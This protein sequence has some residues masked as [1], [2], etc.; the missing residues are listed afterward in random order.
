MRVEHKKSVLAFV[1]IVLALVMSAIG[2]TATS[3]F[4]RLT[5]AEAATVENPT[6]IALSVNTDRAGEY[7]PY[8]LKANALDGVSNVTKT[9]YNTYLL[10]DGCEF[11]VPSDDFSYFAFVKN[12][13]NT[14]TE[15]LKLLTNLTLT[16]ADGNSE[17]ISCATD[18][19][20]LE[21]TDTGI[22]ATYKGLSCTLSLNNIQESNAAGITAKYD[23]ILN[24]T[25][26]MAV[27]GKDPEFKAYSVM[28]N[29][30]V[31][32]TPLG[33]NEFNIP[34]RQ[35]FS[36]PDDFSIDDVVFDGVNYFYFKEININLRSGVSASGSFFVKVRYAGITDIVLDLNNY[37]SVPTQAQT[38]LE[39]FVPTDIDA[40]LTIGENAV[41]PIIIN[42]DYD[43]APL[44]NGFYRNGLGKYKIYYYEKGST[45]PSISGKTD[46]ELLQDETHT[47]GNE[48]PTYMTSIVGTIRI[49][50]VVEANGK[51]QTNSVVACKD[52]DVSDI[53]ILPAAI[54]APTL[55]GVTAL[56][57]KKFEQSYVKSNGSDIGENPY[58]GYGAEIPVSLPVGYTD[59][60][61]FLLGREVK[62][63]VLRGAETVGEYGYEYNGGNI[64]NVK[65]E[66]GVSFAETADGS[67]Y[68]VAENAGNYTVRFE[69]VGPDYK[70]DT[71]VGASSDTLLSYSVT[72]N[73]MKGSAT[74]GIAKGVDE[75]G[76]E[77]TV[78]TFNYGSLLKTNGDIGYGIKYQ[79]IDAELAWT[80]VDYDGTSS[81]WTS[82]IG[83]TAGDATETEFEYSFLYYGKST[84]GLYDVPASA[85]TSSVPTTPGTY[86]AIIKVEAFGNYAE[87][88]SE[89]VEFIIKRQA[90]AFSWKYNLSG[91]PNYKS[92]PIYNAGK[93]DTSDYIYIVNESSGEVLT[94]T[95]WNFYT[96]DTFATVL[97]DYQPIVAGKHTLYLKLSE[98]KSDL[99]EWSPET[100]S[101]IDDGIFEAGDSGAGKATL[102]FEIEK[103]VGNN[104]GVSISGW[105]Y[106]DNANEP[107]DSAPTYYKEIKHIFVEKDV[108]D[109]AKT[110]A[111]ALSGDDRGFVAKY[112][113]TNSLAFTTDAPVNAGDYFV[114]AYITSEYGE[115]S[116][117]FTSYNYCEAAK[118]FT[119]DKKG[120]V[121]PTLGM[122]DF[123][124]D[125]NAQTVELLNYDGTNMTVSISASLP[126]NTSVSADSVLGK[127]T[128]TN[129]DSYTITVKIA[130]E[131]FKNHKWDDPSVSGDTFSFTW[132]IKPYTLKSIGRTLEKE[133][134]YSSSK[135][136]VV[137][138]DDAN[139]SD[140]FFD[141]SLINAS[142]SGNPYMNGVLDT[143]K[144]FISTSLLSQDASK[145]WTFGATYAGKYVV[146]LSLNDTNYIWDTNA[147][148]YELTFDITPV[149]LG[150][151][152][153]DWGT[154]FSYIYD[155]LEHKPAPVFKELKGSDALTAS[156][157]VKNGEEAVARVTEV[158]NYVMA[159][160]GMSGANL[161]GILDG[162]DYNIAY[163]YVMPETAENVTY[164][165]FA[166]T[167]ALL[168]AP[169]FT[170]D[171]VEYNG[172]AFDIIDYIEDYAK[173][174][175]IGDVAQIKFT[176][177]KNGTEAVGG[178][179]PQDTLSLT[180]V[181]WQS[182][183]SDKATIG[184]Y[185]V[186]VTLRDP[187]NYKWK[188]KSDDSVGT[189]NAPVSLT[190]KITPALVDFVLSQD[191]S[192]EK[193]YVVGYDGVEHDFID[194]IQ[195][196]V[197]IENHISVS[198]GK[199]TD[200][201]RAAFGDAVNSYEV[202]VGLDDKTKYNYVWAD[203]SSDPSQGY[204]I[205]DK[206]YFMR[207]DPAA[208]EVDWADLE[209]TY[210]GSYL[211]PTASVSNHFEVEDN[212]SLVLS[213]EYLEGKD[214]TGTSGG[215]ANV[216]D[217]GY[218]TAYVVG[219]T[220]EG[221]ENYKIDFSSA[222]AVK[223]KANFTI[224]RAAVVKPTIE[225]ALGAGNSLGE[226]DKSEH[227][228]V[229]KNYDSARM[230]YAANAHD[231]RGKDVGSITVPHSADDSNKK[232]T[233]SVKRAGD[234]FVT[235]TLS[236]GKN[237]CF[238]DGSTA[239]DAENDNTVTLDF[240]LERKAVNAPTLSRSTTREAG[241]IFVPVLYS[242]YGETV[243]DKKYSEAKDA[244]SSVDFDLGGDWVV[245]ANIVYGNVTSDAVGIYDI[246]L[247][248][249]LLTDAESIYDYAFV[250]E[251][252]DENTMSTLG[253][254][255][256]LLDFE[257]VLK[258]QFRITGSVFELEFTIQSADGTAVAEWTYGDDVTGFRFHTDSVIPSDYVPAQ[259]E[260][261][262]YVYNEDDKSYAAYTGE[263][264]STGSD[265]I[266][267]KA[268]FFAA[269]PKSAGR[270]RA[271]VIYRTGDSTGNGVY[272]Y[273]QRYIVEFAIEKKEVAF[274]WQSSEVNGVTYDAVEN[275]FAAIYDGNSHMGFAA[276]T[277]SQYGDTLGLQIGLAGDAMDNPVDV[278]LDADKNATYYDI[279]IKSI[280]GEAAANYV[281]PTSGLQS[282][283]TIDKRSVTLNA[284]DA[285]HIFG[286]K[287]T[288]DGANLNIDGA[289][290]V[291]ITDGDF[292]AS[293]NISLD[294]FAVTAKKSDGTYVLYN[295]S[296]GNYKT[297]ITP[298]AELTN[299]D[300]TYVDGVFD[301]EQKVI[302][303]QWNSDKFVYDGTDQFANY[304]GKFVWYEDVDANKVALESVDISG[305]DTIF[306][307]AGRYDFAVTAVADANYRLA[308]SGE[309]EYDSLTRSIE[310]QKR[311][312]NIA[313]KDVTTVY[314]D[315]VG[316]YPLGWVYVEGT[317]KFVEDGGIEIESG[318]SA[319]SVLSFG[320]ASTAVGTS[321]VGSYVTYLVYNG[322]N[323]TGQIT[324]DDFTVN[325]EKGAHT[326][327]KYELK[328]TDIV[329]NE[330]S[331]VYNAND[332][333]TQTLGLATYADRG[334]GSTH[335]LL[336]AAVSESGAEVEFKNAGDYT[337]AVSSLQSDSTANLKLPDGYD[338]AWKSA[339]K[340]TIAKREVEIS[341]E[342]SESVYG[343][344]IGS[345]K[346]VWNYVST[347]KF[348]D[349]DENAG[350]DGFTS[351]INIRVAGGEGV[352]DERTDVGFCDLELFHGNDK[353]IATGGKAEFANYSVVFT[354]G[355]IT[356]RPRELKID[357]KNLE[358]IYGSDEVFDTP[359]VSRLAEIS[360]SQIVGG[361]LASFDTIVDVL[362]ATTPANPDGRVRAEAKNGYAV[363]LSLNTDAK[364]D[365]YIVKFKPVSAAGDT[366]AEVILNSDVLNESAQ[367][368]SEVAAYYNIKTA[369]FE[370]IQVVSY[371]ESGIAYDGAVHAAISSKSVSYYGT[372][373]SEARKTATEN[374]SDN[375]LGWA[376]ALS[377]E[378]VAPD[379][380]AFA[381]EIPEVLNA[382]TYYLY[383][384]ISA[385]NHE[386]EIGYV[387]VT[388]TK[389]E[390]VLSVSA[391][392]YYGENTPD[393]QYFNYDFD[394]LGENESITFASASGG[395]VSFKAVRAIGGKE[396]PLEGWIDGTL[397]ISTDYIAGDSVGT[398]RVKVENLGFAA[399]NYVF[400]IAPEEQNIV[401]VEKL[402]VIITVGD[403]ED[404]YWF[405]GAGS[406]RDLN[407]RAE[408]GFTLTTGVKDIAGNSITDVYAG[409]K[410]VGTHEYEKL[411]FIKSGAFVYDANGNRTDMNGVGTYT[412]TYER[413]E[414]GGVNGNYDLSFTLGSHKV[415]PADIELTLKGYNADY[416]ENE[417]DLIV[418]TA[419]DGVLASPADKERPSGASILDFKYAL[420]KVSEGD[421]KIEDYAPS[422]ENGYD[423]DSV[424]KLIDAGTYYVYYMI[425]GEN[426][427]T[428]TGSLTAEIA[429]VY[430]GW[431][432]DKEYA[433][434]KSYWSYGSYDLSANEETKPE[435]NF[436]RV[437]SGGETLPEISL[438][439][440][441]DFATLVGEYS[442]SGEHWSWLT[443]TI[444]G[445]TYNNG[446]LLGAGVYKVVVSVDGNDNFYDLESEYEITVN[447]AELSLAPKAATITYGDALDFDSLKFEIGSFKNGEDFSSEI[448]NEVLR[449]EAGYG[450]D[451]SFTHYA[452][453]FENG[454]VSNTYYIR[455]V[456]GVQ[457]I[458]E[459]M[460][461]LKNYAPVLETAT[462]TVNKKPLLIHI[463]NAEN[464]YNFN[465]SSGEK[466]DPAAIDTDLT[467]AENKDAAGYYYDGE[468]RP[469]G[470]EIPVHIVTD[471]FIYDESGN[472]A[473]STKDVGKYPIYAEENKYAANYDIS[474]EGSYSGG[475]KGTFEIKQAELNIN[476]SVWH[477][478]DG[479]ETEA[480][481]AASGREYVGTYS[482]YAWEFKAEC[483][484][485]DFDDVTFRTVYRSALSGIDYTGVAP[486]N[487][488]TYYLRF[489][490]N[491]NNN[492][493]FAGS[494][495]DYVMKV[496]PLS[497]AVDMRLYEDASGTE[498][499]TGSVEY[500]QS[501]YAVKLSSVPEAVPNPDREDFEKFINISYRK[502]NESVSSPLNA[503]SYL[504]TAT[505]TELAYGNY[506][507]DETSRN[508]QFTITKKKIN[509]VT[510]IGDT[511]AVY[512]GNDI[513]FSLAGCS[514]LTDPN[515]E[516]GYVMTYEIEYADNLGSAPSKF[517][518]GH[519]AAGTFGFGA[520]NAGSYAVKVKLEF[521][522]DYEW[523]GFAGDTVT[524]NYTITQKSLYVKASN[525]KIEYGDLFDGSAGSTHSLLYK[526]LV[527]G[528][529]GQQGTQGNEIPSAGIIGVGKEIDISSVTYA[530]VDSSANAH[531]A[532]SAAGEIFT[533]IPNSDE[534][535]SN[536]YNIVVNHSSFGSGTLSVVG[537][538]ITV[539]IKD[540][541][542]TYTGSKHDEWL[543]SELEASL[544]SGGNTGKYI[545]LK[546]GDLTGNE[547]N[548]T[549]ADLGITLKIGGGNE[550]DC[551]LKGFAI[552]ADYTN[553]NY[554]I[555]FTGSW[556]TGTDGT[557]TIEKKTLEVFVG[558]SGD[559]G[560]AHSVIYGDA[561]IY[562]ATYS[563]F[564]PQGNVGETGNLSA[565]SWLFLSGSISYKT[566]LT[567]GSGA[568]EYT[569]GESHVGDE[570]KV[571]IDDI[572][573]QNYKFDIN[574]GTIAILPRTIGASLTAKTVTF[575]ADNAHIP[576]VQNAP[577]A[578]TNTV[579]GFAS[580]IFTYSYDGVLKD[581][582]AVS[583][584]ADVSRAGD[585][586]V[587][588]NLI[589]NENGEYDYLFA[590]SVASYTFAD[591]YEIAKQ[592]VRLE[593]TTQT[594]EF[595]EGR[596]DE[597]TIP[598]YDGVIL[599]RSGIMLGGAVDMEI[600]GGIRIGEGGKGLVLPVI[601]SGNYSIVLSL[602]PDYANDYIL[603]NRDSPQS[604]TVT[605]SFNT[606]VSEINLT[607]SMSGWTYGD[608]AVE[609]K[610]KATEAGGKDFALD[611]NATIAISYALLSE[612]TIA[613]LDSKNLWNM[614]LT[615]NDINSLDGTR[616][617][618]VSPVNAGAYMV[619]ATGS[620]DYT[621]ESSDTG[622]TE[623]KRIPV[624]A[625]F[626]FRIAKDKID[627]P[628]FDEEGADKVY[629]GS[630]LSATVSGYREGIMSMT[631]AEAFELKAGTITL[632]T[633]SA[634]A[635]E[636][637]VSLINDTNYEWNEFTPSEHTKLENGN[638]IITWTVTAGTNT[639][640]GLTVQTGIYYG[641]TYDS[642]GVSALFGGVITYMYASR[643]TD[644][645]DPSMVPEGLDWKVGFPKGVGK[646]WIGATSQG[647]EDDYASE[648]A[649]A[650]CEI[651]KA[652]LAVRPK[653]TALTYGEAFTIEG[654]YELVGAMYD[655][656]PV[657]GGLPSATVSNEN[658]NYFVGADVG[659]YAIRISGLS[660][661]AVSGELA[662]N[663]S[664]TF[665]G[666]ETATL[667]VNKKSITV[668]INSQEATYD[669]TSDHALDE[670]MGE[671]NGWYVLNN[672]L[673]TNETTQALDTLGIALSLPDNCMNVGNYPISY[674]FT[675]VGKNDNYDIT[676]TP[677]G[678]FV[679][680]SLT[681]TVT[682]ATAGGTLVYNR[683]N[684]PTGNL[685]LTLKY[686]YDGSEQTLIVDS[687]TAS[688]T[689][690][691]ENETFVLRY[692]GVS[693]NGATYSNSPSLPLFAGSGYTVGLVSGTN[694]GNITL[695]GASA[696][697]AVEKYTLDGALIQNAASLKN[698]LKVAYTGNEYS[699][700]GDVANRVVTLGSALYP[701]PSGV[702]KLFTVT[703]SDKQVS[704]GTYGFTLT[705]E[706]AVFHNY[707]WASVEVAS[708]EFTFEIE[709]AANVVR[710]TG[711]NP[712]ELSWVYDG[713]LHEGGLGVT[714][715]FGQ[716]TKIY[717]VSSTENGTYEEFDSVRHTRKGTYYVKV[718]IPETNDYTE[719]T[720]SEYKVCDISARR[721]NLVF[722]GD[723]EYIGGVYGDTSMSARDY[724]FTDAVT[725]LADFDDLKAGISVSIVYVGSS[726]GGVASDGLMPT[727][728]GRY[729]VRISLSGE[730]AHN[731][732]LA[733]AT[734]GYVE[735]NYIVARQAVYG[736]RIV[737]ESFD[738]DGFAHTAE[739]SVKKNE[740]Y[741]VKYELDGEAI[742]NINAS[743]YSF[744]LKLIDSDNFY[745]FTHT[746]DQTAETI[747]KFRSFSYHIKTVDV[748]NAELDKLSFFKNGVKVEVSESELNSETML[749]TYKDVISDVTATVVVTVRTESGREFE[750]TNRTYGTF[751][752]FIE[753]Q[754]YSENY[755]QWGR[756]LPEDAG[757]HKIRVNI[758]RT[759]NINAPTSTSE[760]DFGVEKFALE[761]PT[762][763]DTG[764]GWIYTGNR[765]TAYMDGSFDNDVMRVSFSD[766]STEGGRFTVGAVKAGSHEITVDIRSSHTRNYMWKDGSSSL[767]IVWKIEK[768]RNGLKHFDDISKIYG[769][770]YASEAIAD[771]GQ[772]QFAY[773]D[774][775]GKLLAGAPRASGDYFIEAY[776]DG[777]DDYYGVAAS[778]VKLH[779]SK[780]EIV[781]LPTSGSVVYGNEY[782]HDDRGFLV[783]DGSF[784]YG[785]GY[786]VISG[787]PVYYT[788]YR[789]GNAVGSTQTIAISGVGILEAENYTFKAGENLASLTVTKRPIT[790]LIGDQSASYNG[791]ILLDET[792]WTIHE[793]TPKFG[794]DIIA[795][796]LSIEGG[797]PTSVGRYRIIG[798]AV[799]GGNNS[800]E[801]YDIT[802]R[803]GTYVVNALIIT[804]T[805]ID[806]PSGLV[807]GE[808]AGAKATFTVEGVDGALESGAFVGR[809]EI[810]VVYYDDTT[811]ITYGSMPA[812]AGTYRAMIE[813]APASDGNNNQNYRLGGTLSKVF[814]IARRAI[815]ETSIENSA[816]AAGLLDSVYSGFLRA[817]S[818][819]A[820]AMIEGFAPIDGMYT[821]SCAGGINVG[822]YSLLLT[823]TSD[824][825]RNY[826]WLHSEGSV[827]SL[828]YTIT[829]NMDNAVTA[830]FENAD[831]AT[832][833]YDGN[834][835]E[836]RLESRLV[837]N[838]LLGGDNVFFEY[839][840]VSGDT[841]GEYSRAVPSAV[842]DYR[843]R[844]V[845]KDTTDYS[846]AVST[847]LR[848]EITPRRI[849]ADFAECGGMYMSA[850]VPA[851]AI[852]AYADESF[853]DDRLLK[854][855]EHSVYYYGTSYDGTFSHTLED[856]ITVVPVKA[857]A[858]KAAIV[859][860][861][862]NFVFVSQG[863]E[864]NT[865]ETDFIVARKRL[866]LPAQDGGKYEVEDTKY[867][868]TP[869]GFDETVMTI[870]GNSANKN[871]DYTAIV[872]LKDKANYEWANGTSDDFEMSWTLKKDAPVDFIATVSVLST[873]T[874]AA[875]ALLV[876]MLVRR[877]KLGY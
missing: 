6:S 126:G 299:Y 456:G 240:K 428:V 580:E 256:T 89:P 579:S 14:S 643:D 374:V 85:P 262:Y 106:E 119:V 690:L 445:E 557:F 323:F 417:H 207:V 264:V 743:H 677:S 9:D 821:V 490:A 439:G 689:I 2:F 415:V 796:T 312:V 757:V 858:Y 93:H 52:F 496:N 618:G 492:Y 210:S 291:R 169:T 190:F 818:A 625:W 833:E 226:Y 84:N 449:L 158:G 541:S 661:V 301:V 170:D 594:F 373:K 235:F 750:L 793:S 236:D 741:G 363:T 54:M 164:H 440:G 224:I 72:V 480:S 405:N 51:D 622:T 827:A 544:A 842:G 402:P 770:E 665:D 1:G 805:G 693:N 491:N 703:A 828:T 392:I 649:Y 378:T 814:T 123:T 369:S 385:D 454:S 271:A 873:M 488:G 364:G 586:I 709:K 218:Y 361:G 329:W 442:M 99:Y 75:E 12:A 315:V 768:A 401:S 261:V 201:N 685:S 359:L 761:T 176:A 671:K 593:W 404:S 702:D 590:G 111:D 653:D 712:G 317:D 328:E 149:K 749:W 752:S 846:G 506:I 524:L 29:G 333:T 483:V 786:A 81:S 855:A 804:V 563:G 871:G 441:E 124:F 616:T 134:E 79:P 181:V 241:K 191:A 279:E 687:A 355:E 734:S 195:N 368:T 358:H 136:T 249:S 753:L 42:L 58:G 819:D 154:E 676:V 514:S 197:G 336:L 59:L 760:Y 813:L 472:L 28:S 589:T 664:V 339:D 848:F 310:M 90:I 5:N 266:T 306:K 319:P 640:S 647:G 792:K 144:S 148:S 810:L 617:Y 684:A 569:I 43:R 27:F 806:V 697:F 663:Y 797:L 715:D 37:E 800:N 295:T 83:E 424:P 294:S 56:D 223:P 549:V 485:A 18:G 724:D 370:D 120:V 24:A 416:D 467:S 396:L 438:F 344:K 128:A 790:I 558:V 209:Q 92:A 399:G 553:K 465:I 231:V 582:T 634:G 638:V 324:L 429:K 872:S 121:K 581:G 783:E 78:A 122:L 776:V 61:G 163:G 520:V 474:Y 219:L 497:V 65:I 732:E 529:I 863:K 670:S 114:L 269:L 870:S 296:V 427:N 799:S 22:N 200:V 733:N 272:E 527:Q 215:L 101:G 758:E 340:Y 379:A 505:V 180:D 69:I 844:A 695:I 596:A 537:R 857:G 135:Q 393:L 376:Y 845:V 237:Y 859:L 555:A 4:A 547:G 686:V 202:T 127:L 157:S 731:F 419:S 245:S 639:V 826:K 45:V 281:L 501:P 650:A 257:T 525:E 354:N 536:N 834:S 406:G 436:K 773:Y 476:V 463:N 499:L 332:R 683:G 523:I 7:P 774:K 10:S 156:V 278:K 651:V 607:I 171:V 829:K 115:N 381:S 208:L 737:V 145:V 657:L 76:A 725:G 564:V 495:D 567:A 357:V 526:G 186:V 162:M 457:S 877:K 304:N 337:L 667:T 259:R 592:V 382:G 503:G 350:I 3:Q 602:K 143:D 74:L 470:A 789:A 473:V 475:T 322:G 410:S 450:N 243:A 71:A 675:S 360:A 746:E 679:I 46:E 745:W 234:Y 756:L 105:T 377:T 133:S 660:G 335:E 213:L 50:Y 26:T 606:F 673:V 347:V 742:E 545:I 565:L 652:V 646:Y 38:A 35:D 769:E 286:S 641:E 837:V 782:T 150:A 691:N 591:S 302:E 320:F 267:N 719:A 300:I 44:E 346:R 17:T 507:L 510:T 864:T 633:S 720:T 600:D 840:S 835:I 182:I 738:F 268:D 522:D 570:Y 471:A 574:E 48:L 49:L 462:L 77:N 609:P 403:I 762:L 852:F 601:K 728:A 838:A 425:S 177:Y 433:I 244:V 311:T 41:S 15:M 494:A 251:E 860:Q 815:D 636:L 277:N 386:T 542:R 321:S 314:G 575:A 831:S 710:W 865:L 98:E 165:A 613:S 825:V 288:S 713:T 228:V 468:N 96:D 233:V 611:E 585:Y 666:S 535:V 187:E 293:D 11:A 489:I 739:D 73:P 34:T 222:A 788:A 624:Q 658:G 513:T 411:F 275:M 578:F 447:K 353:F 754:Y 338:L 260:A 345:E 125:K 116:D 284:G 214:N 874:V 508:F 711:A 795:I 316:S 263:T 318:N 548:D 748:V 560:K 822:E 88:H 109:T 326:I 595:A 791:E 868:L 747:N 861:N 110:A 413:R 843:V 273:E 287:V 160:D 700:D 740:F 434:A 784:E 451:E 192:E 53:D 486:K 349:D 519:F 232:I 129:V 706:N 561:L 698:V 632:H 780:K 778:R 659:E 23:K 174:Y 420:I 787:A 517:G 692:S 430:N 292:V 13:A 867:T 113:I 556:S 599:D 766:V 460:E 807:F 204:N 755:A 280:T 348:C 621:Y 699:I 173:N 637:T 540:A 808:T 481:V 701:L 568:A 775:D 446:Q 459:G 830:K 351:D 482:G 217:A 443:D 809:V 282:K 153:V 36:P 82:G 707:K 255:D 431:K 605:L 816:K 722:A 853:S 141:Y 498:A 654:N 327:E 55:N 531:T 458:L 19:V 635:H 849:T 576:V 672:A 614:S 104:L 726:F 812:S 108:Y 511:S 142:V 285:S 362:T 572:T 551:S 630:L 183:A 727:L 189:D 87:A 832:F 461:V 717:L 409:D 248:L 289:N 694:S 64:Q 298:R 423:L 40:Y 152:N 571:T 477:S 8:Y 681:L 603:V 620:V 32:T 225:T 779:I 139:A 543:Q 573:L 539:E 668:I 391:N 175:I 407:V 612:E 103:Y 418:S 811:G 484:N 455:F 383:Y 751:D 330:S 566:V 395:K 185:T 426:H 500:K 824:F 343:E 704:A 66:N 820:I 94:S 764:T 802:F 227:D 631:Y 412:V 588:L 850:I 414:L 509:V 866:E 619:R 389:K 432:T 25:D 60:W 371:S 623:T 387:T 247:T 67:Q 86:Y 876:V 521:T 132:T 205:A 437:P 100:V 246:T 452:A 168:L 554:D 696:A 730:S 117:D 794:S 841:L 528:H 290:L 583:S 270:Y 161:T 408:N 767:V 801:N 341:V 334:D 138:F 466:E 199:H 655:D 265:D 642:T 196:Y 598:N 68:L 546:S 184:S 669:G 469:F 736:D 584:L 798:E 230:S 615:Q 211:S 352:D 130:A 62:M 516:N 70:W 552:S 422:D 388:V 172:S 203:G 147:R 610:L 342:D 759:V 538:K 95:D 723:D 862:E 309:S 559:E 216:T 781:V 47:G 648:T 97:T 628:L 274:D 80:F 151:N 735:G 252:V 307:R 875:G 57:W 229:I 716:E 193:P 532:A 771:F 146:E 534:F 250:K 31:N 297:V 421:G 380:S 212:K 803:D 644:S 464:K 777:S 678:R 836:K 365:N 705:L 577:V 16:D 137:L 242:T 721:I 253:I 627:V 839:A 159:L 375:N 674:K 206:T 656:L 394:G 166:I 744:V 397:D 372:T 276:V 308:V 238:E 303:V 444:S 239:P 118:G 688:T 645:T 390:V 167:S 30:L 367:K 729:K 823:F 112:I 33:N 662:N 179:E 313:A 283:L 487:A 587:T 198:G 400:N 221:A 63:T 604:Q 448:R 626:A 188:A 254:E 680:N 817:P 331:F 608:T 708:R 530:A 39:P 398:Y 20:E 453:G 562:N 220:G 131:Y 550:T 772:V 854:T 504:A 597:N 763:T 384:R 493:T 502:D 512:D 869:S 479:S 785:D 107:V 155:G 356:V 140:E 478:I 847:A 21:L 178:N 91:T 856:G 102:Y 851:S 765:L 325:V 629:G 714:A 718:R 518:D 305:Q 435:A 682:E 533:I 515:R 194:I 366:L 258:V